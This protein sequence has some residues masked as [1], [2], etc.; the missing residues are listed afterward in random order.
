MH[1]NKEINQEIN[2]ELALKI[3]TEKKAFVFCGGG[4]LGIAHVGALVRLYE[5]GGLRN[6]KFVTG[7]SVGSIIALSLAC[8]ASIEYIKSKMFSLNFNE[9]KD[10]DNYISMFFRFLFKYGLYKGDKLE[11]S[12]QEIVNELTGNPK[13]TFSENYNKTKIELI[14]PYLS[15]VQQKMIYDDHISNP[16][17]PIGKASKWSSTIP[18]FFKA[19]KVYKNC[20]L[21][22]AFVDAGTIDNYPLHLAREHEY[23]SREIIGF[24]F[25]S[26]SDSISNENN[27]NN[28]K[29]FSTTLINILREQALRYHVKS[30]D[31][32]ITCKIDIGK[33]K[34]TDFNLTEEDKLFLFNAGKQAMDNY[35][36]EIEELLNNYNL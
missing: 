23:Q 9:F 12:I 20:K 35:L 27:I 24:N 34:S 4:V 18:A 2:K 32:K 31:W 6:I 1:C 21:Q 19:E 28:I 5:L 15:V 7:S 3:L 30:E 16:D 22:D 25:Y 36:T 29:D 11:N 10:G 8:G 13:T 26:S 14:I 17:L 33:Y